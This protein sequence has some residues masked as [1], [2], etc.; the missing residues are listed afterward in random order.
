[1]KML[2]VL[3]LA[4]V[5]LG[6]AYPAYADRGR[7]LP[8]PGS[9]KELNV[10]SKETLGVVKAFFSHLAAKSTNQRVNLRLIT[11]NKARKQMAAG[12]HYELILSYDQTRCPLKHPGFYNPKVCP[13]VQGFRC[14]VDYLV[15]PAS[16]SGKVTGSQC[17]NLGRF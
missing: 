13:R 9:W 12:F 16:N 8:A 17:Q 5:A 14:K 6:S 4:V 2:L 1:M 7:S 3:C 11:V 15:P 10:N